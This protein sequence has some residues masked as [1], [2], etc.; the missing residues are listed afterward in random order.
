MV[1]RTS[2]AQKAGLRPGDRLIATTK[3]APIKDIT[4]FRALLRAHPTPLPLRYIRHGV[5]YDVTLIPEPLPSQEDLLRRHVMGYALPGAQ[6]KELLPGSKTRVQALKDESKSWILL[7]FWATWCAPCRAYTQPFEALA[8]RHKGALEVWSISAEPVAQL[9]QTLG[10]SQGPL[11]HFQDP[12]GL[13]HQGLL[14]REYPLMILVDPDGIVRKVFTGDHPPAHVSATVEGVVSGAQNTG[15]GVPHH[16][17]PPSPAPKK[18]T[19][20]T[21]THP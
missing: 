21:S 12:G 2:A 15:K 16:V 1:V 3:D 6:L 18:T 17:K 13:L 11:R 10:E 14:V 9:R 8:K 7:D 19:S 20:D 5:P 4:A